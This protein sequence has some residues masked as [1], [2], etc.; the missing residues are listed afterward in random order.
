MFE[1]GSL[2]RRRV[3]V[4][5]LGW[6]VDAP[7]RRHPHW[8]LQPFTTLPPSPS[9]P[10]SFNWPR[11]SRD[12]PLASPTGI[13][14]GI[15]LES[16]WKLLLFALD[17][18]IIFFFRQINDQSARLKTRVQFSRFRRFQLFERFSF[19]SFF[20]EKMRSD[21]WMEKKEMDGRRETTTKNEKLLSSNSRYTFVA[22]W[23]LFNSRHARCRVPSEIAKGGEIFIDVFLQWPLVN[24]WWSRASQITGRWIIKK[25]GGRGKERERRDYG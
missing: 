7:E 1:E 24:R 12:P 14:Q 21:R 11:R 4:A 17:S 8:F 3:G 16:S 22:W 2:S 13:P 6:N 15:V 23:V 25:W 19:L 9:S 10:L 5:A 18:P 20:G